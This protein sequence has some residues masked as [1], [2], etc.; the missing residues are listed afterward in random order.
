MASRGLDQLVND[1]VHQFEKFFD[2]FDHAMAELQAP[3]REAERQT[4]YIASTLN[5]SLFH[6]MVIQGNSRQ[7]LLT[8]LRASTSSDTDSVTELLTGQLVVWLMKLFVISDNPVDNL[9]SQLSQLIRSQVGMFEQL[10][11]AGSEIDVRLDEDE[12]VTET[13]ENLKTGNTHGETTLILAA[14]IFQFYVATSTLLAA[15]ET[16]RDPQRNREVSDLQVTLRLLFQSVMTLGI[17]F[18]GISPTSVDSVSTLKRLGILLEVIEDASTRSDDDRDIEEIIS[19]RLH[20]ISRHRTSPSAFEGLPSWLCDQ[21]NLGPILSAVDTPSEGHEPL[22]SSVSS[23]WYQDPS[24]RHELR[25]F[26]GQIWTPQVSDNGTTSLDDMGS[27]SGPL[28]AAGWYQDPSGKY[29]SRFWD[30]TRWTEHVADETGRQSKDMP[31]VSPQLESTTTQ[32]DSNGTVSQPTR[33]GDSRTGEGARLV[34]EAFA[35]QEEGRVDLSKVLEEL[36]ALIGLAEVKLE[37][38]KIAL[39]SKADSQRRAHGLH[40]DAPA[41]HL[42]FVGNPGTGKTTVARL[43]GRIYHATGVLG[44]GHVVETSRADLVAGF[45][46]QT[47]IKTTETI[48]RA[49]GGVLFID[50]AYSMNT[51]REDL[52]GREA[53]DTL[54]KLMEDYRDRLV[55]IAAGYPAE[56][57]EFLDSNTGLRSRFSKVIVFD[58]YEPGD[59]VEVFLSMLRKADLVASEAAKLKAARILVARCKDPGFGNARGVRKL[60]EQVSDRQSIRLAQLPN[61]TKQ[62][63]MQIDEVDVPDE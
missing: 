43:L 24:K 21:K 25:Y 4:G 13:L 7:A 59:L 41:R 14:A 46:G 40:V 47:A 32:D 12:V 18:S 16:S 1:L 22:A 55:V 53:I 20:E 52:F 26:D 48:E 11:R 6:S 34:R 60:I 35:E 19:K 38:E 8:T 54:V 33:V 5:K 44:R 51:G 17:K 50:E 23:G 10:I 58:D 28:P 29:Q 42:V 39:R 2:Q 3:L 56:M 27:T 30:S 49:L 62:Q 45:T 9:P 15:V 63:L 36:S 37:V 61:P 57:E 31:P